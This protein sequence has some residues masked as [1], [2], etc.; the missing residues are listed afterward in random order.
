MVGHQAGPSRRADRDHRARL[1]LLN[2]TVS[3]RLETVFQR[4]EIR[5]ADFAV[6]A[7]LVHLGHA[8]LSQRRLGSELWL[9]PGSISLRVDRLVHRGCFSPAPTR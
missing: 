2:A 1:A 7:T 9:S 8:Q 6:L 3:A 4:F 5:G